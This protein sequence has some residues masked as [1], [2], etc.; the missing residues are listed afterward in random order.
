MG[1]VPVPWC[2]ICVLWS[3]PRMKASCLAP[4]CTLL[5]SGQPPHLPGSNFP[6]LLCTLLSSAC[7]FTPNP[8]GSVSVT[9]LLLRRFGLLPTSSFSNAS[10]SLPSVSLQPVHLCPPLPLFPLVS[11]THPGR[12]IS[13]GFISL[14]LH[15]FLG[16]LIMHPQN[17]N[18]FFF[19]TSPGSASFI[20]S[21]LAFLYL[22]RISAQMYF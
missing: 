7:G 21:R 18:W 5:C 3:F 4:T 17:C 13:K 22:L 15:S 19:L 10:S 16:F 12:G 8:M 14:S 6:P 9:C 2:G 1:K 11:P 20:N